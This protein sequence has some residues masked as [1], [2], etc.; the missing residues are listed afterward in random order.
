MGAAASARESRWA[1]WGPLLAMLVGGVLRFVNL[2]Q[3]HRLIFD[4][5]YYVK[6]GWSLIQFGY[7]RDI[8]DDL[9]EPDELFTNGTADVFGSAPDLVV[10]PPVGKWMIGAGEWLFG[11]DSSFGWRFAAALVGT[12]SILLLGRIAW[13]MWRNATLATVAATL[14]AVDGHHFVHSRTGLLDIFLMWW[15]LVAFYFLLKDR[16]QARERLAVR[17]GS[18]AD[19]S[20]MSWGPHLGMRW[21]R[22][23]AGVS[24]GLAC[25]TKW[26]GAFFLAVFGI[27]TVLWDMNARRAA[28]VS[29]WFKGGV[30]KDGIPAF[31]SM[32]GVAALTYLA[33][34]T[35]WFATE[36]GWKRDWAQDHP[37]EGLA[38]IV[39]DPLRSLFA[40]HQEVLSFHT[41]L[42]NEHAWASNPWTWIVQGRPTLFFSRWPS[43]G[44]DGCTVSECTRYIT[45]LGNLFV[46]WGA[47]IGIFIVLFLWLFGR[48]WRAGA[49]LS[50]VIAG[51]LPWFLYQTR[52]I[53]SFYAIAFT[54]WLVLI[55][56]TVLALILGGQEASESRRFWG[57]V[58]VVSYVLLAVLFFALYY[59]VYVGQLIPRTQWS[60]LMFLPS[61]T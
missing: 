24:L 50:G 38:R 54:P 3:I 10:H 15:V 5:T 21:W 4:E 6:Q 33:S 20:F 48:D 57:R 17:W 30:F 29:S 41:G 25:G 11:I 7:E 22:I 56:V 55:V 2:G 35:G 12:L 53:Y 60:L 42:Q 40:Y 14:L 47:A 46:W 16:E 39:P 9:E 19:R 13:L 61:W 45:S 36:G 8:K 27:M 43:Q 18:V 51:W 23:A 37:A 32:V 26:S 59:P 31:F 49:A 52:T 58:I 1:W 28:G 34:W 44:E